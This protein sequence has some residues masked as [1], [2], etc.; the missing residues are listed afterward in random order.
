MIYYIKIIIIILLVF[1]SIFLLYKFNTKNIEYFEDSNN[2]S[3]YPNNSIIN[4]I[5]DET[6]QT[7]N[8]QEDIKKSTTEQEVINNINT[9]TS[10]GY[11]NTVND[12][13]SNKLD[14]VDSKIQNKLAQFKTN[15]INFQTIPDENGVDGGFNIC[16]T[17]SSGSTFC[18]FIP[19]SNGNTYIRPGKNDSDINIDNAKNINLSSSSQNILLSENNTLVTNSTNGTNAL[20]ANGSDAMCSY[21]PYSDNN[22]Y[23]RPAKKDGWIYIG[24]NANDIGGV[25][26]KSKQNQFLSSDTDYASHLPNTNG[27]SYIRPG[28][29]D[30]N[31]YIG[32]QPR[33]GQAD[34]TEATN[35][36]S[37]NSKQHNICNSL[38]NSLCSY[39]PNDDGNTYI[40]PGQNDKNIFI[41][42]ADQINF[43]A[44]KYIFTQN[45]DGSGNTTIF[46]Q[47][48]LEILK[49]L[50][51]VNSDELNNIKLLDD[52]DMN[53]LKNLLR[54]ES[55]INNLLTLAN[56]KQDIIASINTANTAKT[57]ADFAKITANEAKA[58]ANTVNTR[59]SDYS[60]YKPML[61]NMYNTGFTAIS[62]K[63]NWQNVKNKNPR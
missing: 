31:I 48:D 34:N 62:N 49:T 24:H 19:H 20:C 36:I 3:N 46:T 56:N 42:N 30:G 28:K 22:S 38:P 45:K 1:F 43:S 29:D 25:S 15:T 53:K 51:S 59:T 10:S 12:M 33:S 2:Q 37:F 23:I 7:K 35:I 4:K 55:N 18:S 32:H 47:N 17:S 13:L 9:L 6:D 52:I 54:L 21:L 8:E 5:N 11:L 27:N 26:I 39:F 57:T 58:T 61:E 44:N 14:V 60:V 41:D 16:N 40:R 63:T 50:V